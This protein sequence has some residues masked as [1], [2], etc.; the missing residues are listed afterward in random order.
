MVSS[1]CAAMGAKRHL[2]QEKATFCLT[3]EGGSDKLFTCD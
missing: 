3:N 2:T 1:L